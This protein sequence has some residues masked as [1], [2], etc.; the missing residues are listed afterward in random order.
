MFANFIIL[1]VVIQDKTYK[2]FQQK[3]YNHLI[4]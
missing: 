4:L 2:R 3:R 1:I